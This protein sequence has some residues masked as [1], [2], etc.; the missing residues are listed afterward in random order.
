MPVNIAFT[1]ARALF[2]E[3]YNTL[4]LVYIFGNRASLADAAWCPYNLPVFKTTL[5]NVLKLQFKLLK[6]LASSVL[7]KQVFP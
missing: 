3:L 1:I 4:F 5:F 6:E 2:R 7:Q